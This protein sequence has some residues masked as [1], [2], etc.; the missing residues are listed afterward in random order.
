[1]IRYAMQSRTSGGRDKL[2]NTKLVPILTEFY[3]KKGHKNVQEK[4]KRIIDFAN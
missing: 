4:V 1:M 2:L 3:R